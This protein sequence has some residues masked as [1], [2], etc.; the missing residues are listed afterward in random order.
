[1]AK[2]DPKRPF[3][4]FLDASSHLYKRVCPSVGPSVRPLVR[5]AFVKIAENGVMQ[6][7]AHLM[8]CIRPCF[9]DSTKQ[10]GERERARES[11]RECKR[12]SSFSDDINE[13][14]VSM[15]VMV[16]PHLTLSFSHFCFLS[17]NQ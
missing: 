17:L 10:K 3:N 4:A 7:E 6:G 14:E 15:Q 12:K 13:D 11:E 16:R 2:Y 1:M 9:M 8:S 5:N